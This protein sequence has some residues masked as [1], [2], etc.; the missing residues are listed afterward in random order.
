M[1]TEY[2]KND[3]VSDAEGLGANFNDNDI[4]MNIFHEDEV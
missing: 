4:E 3:F 2:E 1:N